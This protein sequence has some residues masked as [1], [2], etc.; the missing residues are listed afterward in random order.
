MK[1]IQA[2]TPEQVA[3]ARELFL[4]YA[5]WLNLNMCFQDFE[6]ELA[7]LPGHYAA[8]QGRLLLAFVADQ[9]AGCVA[10]RSLGDGVCEMKRLYLR[11]AFRGQGRGRQLVAA[12]IEAAVNIGY[13]RLRLDTLPGKMDQAIL[14]Y[15]SLGFKEIGPYYNNPVPGATYMELDLLERVGQATLPD[16]KLI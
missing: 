1:L 5:S 2:T 12:I 11:P 9:L 3:L 14:L 7:E 13:A 4:E 16:R 8:P 15:R 10:L 6:Q